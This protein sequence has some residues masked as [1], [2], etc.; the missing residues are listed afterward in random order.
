M[1]LTQI[2]GSSQIK[3]GT[4]TDAQLSSSAAISTSKLA[5]GANF[6]KKDGSVAFTGEVNANN[7]KVINVAAPTAD[8]DAVNLLTL[9]NQLALLLKKDGSV[10]LTGDLNAG[11]NKL[12]NLAEPVAAS[13]ATT[14]SYVDGLDGANLKKDG[15]VALT[16]NLNANGNKIVNL[17]TPTS[18]TDAASKGYVDGIAQGLQI[19]QSVKVA[20]T[21]NITLSGT[22]TVDGVALSAGDRVLVKNQTNGVQ[23][24]IYVVASGSWSRAADLDE[25]G[26]LVA[27]IFTFVE[28]GAVNGDS[29]WVLVSDNPLILGTDALSF[30]QFSG[31][32]AV[33]AGSG[34]SRTGNTLDIASAN[35]ALVVNA[36]DLEVVVADA[37]LEITGSGLKIASGTAG[38]VL[39]ANASGV[40]VAQT[41]S[42]D[43]AS[44]SATGV[45]TL[46]GTITSKS[47]FVTRETPSGVVNG[48]N[49]N[50]TLAN[51]PELGSEQVFVNGLLMDAGGEDYSISGATIT[52]VS[53]PESGDKIRVNYIK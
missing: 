27:S 42:G 28:K 19:K 47:S 35:G 38:Q 43:I 7:N 50:F 51:T 37:S 15:S 18:A 17:A 22:Q 8:G 24:G 32:G 53:A 33:V 13:D 46:A 11:G 12:S 49:A 25:V 45:V 44:I 16:G 31:A 30:S 41:L 2:R 9:N 39:V 5:D 29:G 1:A 34:L 10:A 14:K 52:F 36:D 23:N 20:T 21:A 3:A 48:T 6:L 26:E 40:P 4:I